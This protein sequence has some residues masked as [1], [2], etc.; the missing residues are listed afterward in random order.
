MYWLR[1]LLE[2]RTN[3]SGPRIYLRAPF[4]SYK[5]FADREFLQAEYVFNKKSAKQIAKE[6]GCSH[7]TILKYL[8][9]F[10]FKIRSICESYPKGQLPYGK[11]LIEGKVQIHEIEA[12]VIEKIKALRAKGFS[13]RHIACV[14]NTLGIET[15][16]E[17]SRWHATTVMKILRRTG[18]I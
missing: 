11:H 12:A 5:L 7:S 4:S 6:C 17:T 2:S 14:L 15:K 13:Y 1:T 9:E 3:G 16:H 10:G 18:Q 8:R